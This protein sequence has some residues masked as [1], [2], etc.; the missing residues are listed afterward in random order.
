LSLRQTHIDQIK[1][2][3]I[4][5][6]VEGLED[7]G[8]N[9]YSNTYLTKLRNT[10]VSSEPYVGID[11]DLD[12]M[13]AQIIKR[14]GKWVEW[15]AKKGRSRSKTAQASPATSTPSS[16]QSV[17]PSVTIKTTQGPAMPAGGGD[18]PPDKNIPIAPTCQG[19]PLQFIGTQSTTGEREAEE[20]K[21]SSPAPTLLPHISSS[22][23]PQITPVPSPHTTPL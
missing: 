15:I 10:P 1:T 7:D 4:D 16:S 18:Q 19:G 17:T 8:Q 13:V 14:T 2:Y 3:G 21:D 11:E 6:D 22:S 12:V 5:L 9:M 23:S 20:L